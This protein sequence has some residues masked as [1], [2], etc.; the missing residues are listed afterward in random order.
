MSG[1]SLPSVLDIGTR[2]TFK[3]AKKE[4]DTSS[5][6]FYWNI[7]FHTCVHQVSIRL[8]HCFGQNL[9]Q[10]TIIVIEKSKNNL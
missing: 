10:Q 2:D 8:P 3:E 7:F 4:P 1:R 5:N 9:M 6:T